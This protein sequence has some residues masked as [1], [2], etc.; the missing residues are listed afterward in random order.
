ML[1]QPQEH[2]DTE[3]ENKATNIAALSLCL[4]A[5][6]TSTKYPEHWLVTLS[7]PKRNFTKKVEKDQCNGHE[8]WSKADSQ[9]EMRR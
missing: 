8:T 5:N 6:V 2:L 4:Q 1:Q 9:C 3:I 7:P